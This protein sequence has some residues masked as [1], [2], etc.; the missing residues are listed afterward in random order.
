MSAKDLKSK[1]IN[2]TADITSYMRDYMRK[3]IKDNSDSIK[4]DICNGSYKTYFAKV[5]ERSIKHKKGLHIKT[6]ENKIN[7]VKPPVIFYKI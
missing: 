5:H 2:K 1:K 7:N 4:C 3:Y 6:L